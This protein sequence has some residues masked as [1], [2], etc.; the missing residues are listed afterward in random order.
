MQSAQRSDHR[1]ESSEQAGRRPRRL[2]QDAVPAACGKDSKL[3]ARLIAIRILTL[4]GIDQSIVAI[5]RSDVRVVGPA[6][7]VEPVELP[8]NFRRRKVKPMLALPDGS[9]KRCKIHTMRAPNF[10]KVWRGQG[11]MREAR[12]AIVCER[13]RT[14]K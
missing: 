1:G 8:V 6:Q 11:Q 13:A 9:M 14:P 12:F 3:P 2:L 5:E 4:S 10:S 7:L